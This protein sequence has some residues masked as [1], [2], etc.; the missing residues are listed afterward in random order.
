MT[1][2]EQSDSGESGE[3]V[4]WVHGVGIGVNGPNVLLWAC[5]YGPARIIF[6]EAMTISAALD[7]AIDQATRNAVG[8]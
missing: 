3:D 8:G 4:R 2:P 7:D 6:D 5:D 1:P